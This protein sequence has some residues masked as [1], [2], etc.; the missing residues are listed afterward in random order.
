MQN[1]EDLDS[2]SDSLFGTDVVLLE[3]V[4][5]VQQG[6]EFRD[7]NSRQYSWPQLHTDYLGA[8]C[9]Q[10]IQDILST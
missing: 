1:S 9:L 3:N 2:H 5:I 6:K 7:A 4:I 10:A 8:G